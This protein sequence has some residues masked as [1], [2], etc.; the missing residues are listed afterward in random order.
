MAPIYPIKTGP[1][2]PLKIGRI[3]YLNLYPIFRGLEKTVEEEGRYRFFD[4][5][6]ALVNSK[7]RRGYVDASPSSSI[8]YL[9]APA[10]YSLIEGH[11]ISS[12]GP[13]RS[14][15]LFSRLPIV[16]L[17]GKTIGITNQTETSAALLKIVLKKFLGVDFKTRV[18][19]FPVAQSL[20]R[21]GACLSIGDDAM[22][23][24]K[25]RGKKGG[26][27]ACFM[28]DLGLLW[29]ENTGLPFVYA[30]WIARKNSVSRN[31]KAFAAFRR[32]LERAKLYAVSH[33]EE[34][35]R[36]KPLN[37]L[38]PS[39][40]LQYWRGISYGLDLMEKKGLALFRKYAKELDLL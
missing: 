14:I 12:D 19:R 3:S 9:K 27:D 2:Y 11:S 7:L 32:D 31:K 23:A 35:A 39:E 34:A 36:E 40:V 21:Y 20:Q 26:P 6:P 28:Y 24:R 38:D 16:E 37:G 25:Q 29:K 13:I 5:H 15:Y 33:L 30:L 10:D 22:L 8:V 17:R 1:I 18:T 4:G